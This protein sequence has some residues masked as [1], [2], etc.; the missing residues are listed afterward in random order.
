MTTTNP[1]T[2]LPYTSSFEEEDDA[3][4]E[5]MSPDDSTLL[6]GEY[7]DSESEEYQEDD[8]NDEVVRYGYVHVL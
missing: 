7:V 8:D 6:D 5:L 1:Y 3:I 4:D 2:N